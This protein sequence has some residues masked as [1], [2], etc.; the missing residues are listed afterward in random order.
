M[1]RY[2]PACASEGIRFEDNHVFRCPAC[3]FVY[4]HNT[5]AAT[6]VLIDTGESILFVR[7]GEEPAKGKLDLPGGFVDPHE[8]A[9]DG[10]IRECREELGWMPD[11][12]ALSLFASFPNVY[13]YKNIVY[14]TCDL[15]FTVRIPGFTTDMTR[16]RQG[17]IDGILLIKYGDIRLDEIAF[18]SARAAVRLFLS[19][20]HKHETCENPRQS[21]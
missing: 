18:D 12:T 17:E 14:N 10:I 6:A 19:R 8:G 21:C 7:R 11:M 4:Y 9:I 20:P 2:C 15:F 3:G 1:F 5:A 16:P 13:P